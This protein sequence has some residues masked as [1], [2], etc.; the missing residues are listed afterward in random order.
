[1]T[2]FWRMP[3]DSSAR[4]HPGLVGQLE[5]GQQGREAA[6]HVG[7]P[8]EP[9]GE[10]Q[11]LL[12]GEVVE[13]VGLVRHEGEQPLGGDRVALQVVPTDRSPCRGWAG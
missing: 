12:D 1:M 10:A 9:G 6:L 8:V 3:R 4:Q 11:V 2:S 7:H 13:Q 5:L